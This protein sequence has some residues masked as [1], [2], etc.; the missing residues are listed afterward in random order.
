MTNKYESYDTEITGKALISS[1]DNNFIN[2][3]TVLENDVKIMCYLSD[4]PMVNDDIYI[5][6]KKY[7]VVSIRELN[8]NGELPIYYTIQG[9]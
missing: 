8:P 2:G 1:Y 4:K 9:R 7:N 3:T 6:S 5:G